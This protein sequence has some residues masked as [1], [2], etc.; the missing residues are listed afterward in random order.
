MREFTPGPE[1]TVTANGALTDSRAVGFDGAQISVAG[2]AMFGLA[3]GSF[4]DGEAARLVTSGAPTGESGGAFSRGNPLTTDAQGR[5][6]L[7]GPLAVQAGATTVTST[8]ANG[9]ILEG[10]EPPEVIVAY[11]LEDAAGAGEFPRIFI[12]R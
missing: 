2:A 8:A 3:R 11:A 5:F 1:H 4:S 7:A 9:E 10:G 6:V 12:N